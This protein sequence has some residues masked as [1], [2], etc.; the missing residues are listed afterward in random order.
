MV[1]HFHIRRKSYMV[2]L[3]CM[4]YIAHCLK[5]NYY[6]LSL[7]YK[8]KVSHFSYLWKPV[9]AQ[10]K[11]KFVL[12]LI[13]LDLR[14]SYRIRF[15]FTSTCRTGRAINTMGLATVNLAHLILQKLSEQKSRKKLGLSIRINACFY[16]LLVYGT[17]QYKSNLII[18]M[19]F[20]VDKMGL[21]YFLNH[22][23]SKLL[24]NPTLVFRFC[25]FPN[26]PKQIHQCKG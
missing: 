16:S 6:G 15:H 19:R 13:V 3:A 20:L 10:N 9:R 23:I 18:I 14:W 8:E 25:I 26:A 12:V 7:S 5:V 24:N 22:S 17:S 2:F 21:I 1:S 4:V 11:N